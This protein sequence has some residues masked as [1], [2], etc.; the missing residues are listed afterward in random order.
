MLIIFDNLDMKSHRSIFLII[1]SID[2]IFTSSCARQFADAAIWNIMVR[3]DYVSNGTTV[4]PTG[5]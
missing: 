3:H 4:S 2:Q 5:N 1:R